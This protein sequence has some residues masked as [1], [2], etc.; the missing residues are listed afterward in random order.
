[1]TLPPC[2]SRR[3][4]PLSKN[5]VARLEGGSVELEESIKIYERG[6]SLRKHCEAKLREAEAR[7]EKITLDPKGNPTGRAPLMSSEFTTA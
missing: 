6:E 1:M 2:A 7:I 5:I 3:H 4:W